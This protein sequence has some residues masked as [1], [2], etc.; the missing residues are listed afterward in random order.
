MI[1]LT[2]DEC[3]V[4]GTMIEKAQTVPGQYPITLNA[5]TTGC[6]QKNNRDP[7]IAYTEDQ[8]FEALD[9]LR[10]KGIVREVM[11]SG[12]RVAKFRHVA[13]DIFAVNT[14]E[15]VLL[16]ELWLRGPQSLAELKAN[17]GRMAP[18]PS[19]DMVTSVLTGLAQRKDPQSGEP[20][21]YVKELPRRAGERTTRFVQLLCPGLHFLGP[22]AES[23]ANVSS[24][25]DG[26]SSRGGQGFDMA[27]PP[28]DPLGQRVAQLESQLL[29]LKSSVDSLVTAVS[30]LAEGVR[31]G[32][33]R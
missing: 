6:N 29:E 31:G 13:R 8:I 5:L 33:E 14:E 2:S 27:P 7:V 16:A 24:S 12:S 18:L 19:L 21:P 10:S 11:L 26:D 4:L 23:G 3:R 20:S 25:T 22:A 9:S 17:A 15:L 28:R 30:R 32:G 1:E